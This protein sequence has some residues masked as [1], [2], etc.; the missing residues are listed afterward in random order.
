MMDFF[1]FKNLRYLN[2][3]RSS[4]GYL[5]E[6][7]YNTQTSLNASLYACIGINGI[8]SYLA[9]CIQQNYMFNPSLQNEPKTHVI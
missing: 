7:I 1:Y 3:F 2:C 8:T 4:T 5:V 9:E 6:V